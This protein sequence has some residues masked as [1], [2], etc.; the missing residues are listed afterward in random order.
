MFK[1]FKKYFS[2]FHRMWSNWSEHWQRRLCIELQGYQRRFTGGK[3][4]GW[5]LISSFSSVTWVSWWPRPFRR[6]EEV[7]SPFILMG[8]MNMITDYAQST[9]RY[10]LHPSF[11]RL[12]SSE[13]SDTKMSFFRHTN[14]EKMNFVPDLSLSQWHT[15]MRF[16]NRCFPSCFTMDINGHL[17]GLIGETMNYKLELTSNK[18]HVTHNPFALIHSHDVI[19]LPD[20]AE[21]WWFLTVS[22]GD[23]TPPT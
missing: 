13:H 17:N 5:K 2:I 11:T 10:I 14:Q 12:V 21:G 20:E 3:T 6:Q 4:S 15:L 7:L 8:E 9:P 16:G 1:M 23:M 19:T 18:Y 22:M